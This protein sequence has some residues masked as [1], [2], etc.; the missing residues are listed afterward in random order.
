MLTRVVLIKFVLKYG[1]R[2]WANW[3][4]RIRN[5]YC[6]HVTFDRRNC[7]LSGI[8]D[9]FIDHG[10]TGGEV[11]VFEYVKNINFKFYIIGRDGVEIQYPSIVHA[12]QSCSPLIDEFVII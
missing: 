2:L 10:L 8:L 3:V 7:L 12:S 4:L 11:L 1:D 6:L 9:L 5:G